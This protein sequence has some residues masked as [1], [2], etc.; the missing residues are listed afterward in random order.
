MLECV[1]NLCFLEIYFLCNFLNWL[2]ND[3]DSSTF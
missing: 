3:V 1:I 2:S